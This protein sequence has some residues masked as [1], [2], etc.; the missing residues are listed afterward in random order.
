MDHV[1]RHCILDGEDAAVCLGNEAKLVLQYSNSEQEMLAAASKVP[2]TSV[3]ISPETKLQ[4]LGICLR[5]V[6]TILSVATTPWMPLDLRYEELFMLR[7]FSSKVDGM[8]NMIHGPYI[9]SDAQ[10]CAMPGR[11]TPWDADLCLLR[12]GIMILE[13]IHGA[14]LRDQSCYTDMAPPNVEETNSQRHL[15]Y[16]SFAWAKQTK[17]KLVACFGKDDGHSL[18][19]AILK[20]IRFDFRYSPKDPNKG[21]SRLVKAVFQEVVEPLQ[22][23]H[24]DIIVR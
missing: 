10:S 20:C 24:P 18:N 1:H 3:I 17:D 12:L 4:R 19:E 23:C 13:L 5:L 8:S 7:S 22:D 14:H 2:L 16:S 9:A 21:D 11:P 6:F 15:K